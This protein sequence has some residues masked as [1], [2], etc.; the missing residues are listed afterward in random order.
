MTTK[1]LA[2]HYHHIDNGGVT[3]SIEDRGS[4]SGAFLV[5]EIQYYGYPSLKTEIEMGGNFGFLGS[6]WLQ[7]LGTMFILASEDVAEMEREYKRTHG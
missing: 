7:Q 2:K 6:Q 1:V 3:F 4:E 5:I